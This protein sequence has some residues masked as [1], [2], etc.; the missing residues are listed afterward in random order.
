MQQPMK[1]RTLV[2]LKPEA[3]ENCIV[4][5]VLSFFDRAGLRS[6]AMKQY[7]PLDFEMEQHYKDVI[8]RVGP[9]IGKDI[10]HRMTR[11]DCIFCVYEGIGSIDPVIAARSV[12]GATDPSKADEGTIRHRF[13]GSVQYNVVHAS[14]SPES[15]EREIGIWFPHLAN[16]VG[17]NHHA[18][19]ERD[20][21]LRCF[22]C[23]GC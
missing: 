4:G 19:N 5:S 6:V 15:A 20:E 8:G 21:N 17:E 18:A 13:G 16:K 10:V 3:L 23:N 14:D 7:K 22:E 11:G 1:K 9:I 2:I 12:V